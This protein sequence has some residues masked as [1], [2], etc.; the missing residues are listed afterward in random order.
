[1]NDKLFVKHKIKNNNS[2]GFSLMEL[3]I[4]IVIIG[5]LAGFGS[6]L[7]RDAISAGISSKKLTDSAWQARL[8][9]QRMA[10]DIQNYNYAI[11]PNANNVTFATIYNESVN[12]DSSGADL[13]RNGQIIATGISN[14][15]FSYWRA[16]GTNTTNPNE[17]SCIEVKAT[18]TEGGALLPLQTTICPRNLSL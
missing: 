9:F 18:V 6:I 8:A 2:Y 14:L 3:I 15:N 1:M 10:K 7:L 5:I 13:L 17:I 4:V 16:D 11:T 12:Y